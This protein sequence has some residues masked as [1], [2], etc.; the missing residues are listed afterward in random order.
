MTR[1]RHQFEW[2]AD[3]GHRC[4][5]EIAREC[6]DLGETYE[7]Y[8]DQVIASDWIQE[9]RDEL[10]LDD[11]QWQDYCDQLREFIVEEL[12][13]AAKR[14]T[15]AE[16]EDAHYARVIIDQARAQRWTPEQ[17]IRSD[18]AGYE[19]EAAVVADGLARLA[20]GRRVLHD[21]RLV[22]TETS[23]S[24]AALP[25]IPEAVAEIVRPAHHIGAERRYVRVGLVPRRLYGAREFRD[26]LGWPES[27]FS[28]WRVRGKLPEPAYQLAAGPVWTEEQV[29]EFKRRLRSEHS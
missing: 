15:P 16:V 20:R 3:L 8:A 6:R 19:N 17:V 2:E 1:T 29:E 4:P 11:D 7:Q 18:A 27:R 26:A 28:V 24:A 21:F 25:R 5:E 12:R 22:Y 9:R 10:G 14:V 23:P 13:A